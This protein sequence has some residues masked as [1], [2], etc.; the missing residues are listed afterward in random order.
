MPRLAKRKAELEALD[1]NTINREEDTVPFEEWPPMWNETLADIYPPGSIQY[2]KYEVVSLYEMGSFAMS[3]G[4]LDGGPRGYDVAGAR[5]AYSRGKATALQTIRT[6]ERIFGE[7]IAESPTPSP[8]AEALATAKAAP[9][10]DLQLIERLLRRF[11]AAAR[12]LRQRHDNRPSFVITDEYDVQ[13]LLQGILRSL[14][15]DVR[16]EEYTPSYAGGAS[17]MDF[18]L[19][20]EQIV[21][22]V[23]MTSDKL[24]DKQIG[25]QLMID[26]Q[27]YSSHQDCKRLVCFVYDP[28]GHLKN[29]RGLEADLTK[30]YNGLIVKVIISSH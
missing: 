9:P 17:R 13:D 15:D 7:R 3:G 26:I 30:S 22:E 12:P 6:I 20:Y 8:L 24:R 16:P 21:I 1:P 18:L 5:E 27:R 11:H 4:F 19:K 25:E 23:K 14:F 2:N 28:G 29:P 10:D